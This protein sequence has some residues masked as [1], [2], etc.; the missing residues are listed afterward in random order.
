MPFTEFFNLLDK[1][2]FGAY[3]MDINRTILFWNRNAER[4]TGHSARQVVGRQC[5]EVLYGLPEQPL[6]LRCTAGCFTHSLKGA[7]RIS[8]VAQVRMRCASRKPRRVTVIVLLVPG[9]AAEPPVLVHLFHDRMPGLGVWREREAVR[10]RRK[11]G[12]RAG[13]QADSV[14]SSASPLTPR[15][16]EMVELLAEGYE[17]EAIAERLHLSIHTVRNYVRNA[18]EKLHAPSRLALVLAAQRLDLQ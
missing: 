14:I 5:Y 4:L 9:A 1:V 16:R 2:P 15:E 17:L 3:V 8:P 7:E 12:P 10:G 13:L 11:Q 18:R 6:A